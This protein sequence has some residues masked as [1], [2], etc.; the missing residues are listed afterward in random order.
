[1][2]V[3]P[4]L[5]VVVVPIFL[6]LVSRV[7]VFPD[8]SVVEVPI[9]LPLASLH[10]V[11]PELL[12]VQ[13]PSFLP[14]ESLQVVLPKLSVLQVYELDAATGTAVDETMANAIRNAANFFDLKILIT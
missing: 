10:V 13:V 1:V 5:F 12:V 7:V 4:K 6:P 2:V 11:L 14:P 8:L 3:L 9:L